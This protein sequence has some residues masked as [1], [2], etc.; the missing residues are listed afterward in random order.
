M[1]KWCVLV[2]LC[3]TWCMASQQ[4]A[5]VPSQPERRLLQ[6]EHGWFE[7]R[8]EWDKKERAA[9][10]AN[11]IEEEASTLHVKKAIGKATL[12]STLVSPSHEC[13]GRGNEKTTVLCTAIMSRRADVVKLLLEGNA[14]PDLPGQWSPLD[15]AMNSAIDSALFKLLIDHKVTLKNGIDEPLFYFLLHAKDGNNVRAILSMLF[16]NNIDLTEWV[17][18]THITDIDNACYPR[19]CDTGHSDLCR[20]LSIVGVPNRG[21][22]V[23]RTSP[24]EGLGDTYVDANPKLSDRDRA[25][26]LLVALTRLA[27]QRATDEIVTEVPSEVVNDENDLNS[28][29][30]L[31]VD[32]GAKDD[33]KAAQ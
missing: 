17:Q 20:Y 18:R 19:W 32:E 33:E 26:K 29:R 6:A 4:T 15:L 22:I 12:N 9:F 27:R 5:L 11:L 21:I 2:V 1:K 8:D 25:M 30:A 3:N 24:I 31:S 10:L 28:V 7:S 13:C 14:N 23:H 16:E